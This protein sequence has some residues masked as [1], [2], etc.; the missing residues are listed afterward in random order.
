MIAKQCK[1]CGNKMHVFEG[2]WIEA[3]KGEVCRVCFDEIANQKKPPDIPTESAGKTPGNQRPETERKN[4][5]DT[6]TSLSKRIKE[7]EKKLLLMQYTLI[8]LAAGI[9]AAVLL[10]VSK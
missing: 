10:A 5:N 7:I 3:Y 8:I 9:V 4:S 1:K 6:D 2:Y